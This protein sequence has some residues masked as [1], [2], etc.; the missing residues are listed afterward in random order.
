MKIKFFFGSFFHIVINPLFWFIVPE[1]LNENINEW[2]PQK[3]P[4]NVSPECRLQHRKYLKKCEFNFLC[5]TVHFNWWFHNVEIASRY[6]KNYNYKN[7]PDY[8]KKYK[9][10][11][12]TGYFY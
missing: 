7:D 2:P 8:Q 3:D 6:P 10:L 12:A 9:D 5:F 11:A 4:V 1:F